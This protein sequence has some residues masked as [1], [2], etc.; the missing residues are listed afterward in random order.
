MNLSEYLLEIY[1]KWDGTPE[2]AAIL[3]RYLH[4]ANKAVF[5]IN[6]ESDDPKI[7]QILEPLVK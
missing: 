1:K 2:H 6:I 4:M 7:K 5:S 3:L